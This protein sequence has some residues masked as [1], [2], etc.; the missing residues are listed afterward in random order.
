ML[1][2]AVAVVPPTTVTDDDLRVLKETLNADL[3]TPELR[4]FALVAQRSGLDPFAKQ[5]FAVKR[6]GKVTFQTSQEGYLSIAARTG[7]Y[8]GCD[9]PEYGPLVGTPPHP[10]WA[11]V[12]VYRKGMSKGVAATAFWSEYVPTDNDFMWRKMPRVMLAKVAR[13]AALRLAFPYVYADLYSEDEMAQADNPSV[14]LVRDN[15]GRTADPTTGEIV[16]RSTTEIPEVDEAALDELTAP[17]EGEWSDV[18]A[19]VDADIEDDYVTCGIHQVAWA[20]E[21]G[22]LWHKTDAGKYCRHPENVRKA[23]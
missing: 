20:G 23:R 21:P 4:L 15:E 11:T 12:R 14:R 5:I 8:D 1:R 6:K 13:V 16:A 10:E 18:A 9:E 2:N 3:T 7:E 17:V 22:D 19:I